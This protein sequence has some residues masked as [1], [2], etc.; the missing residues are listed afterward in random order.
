M[1]RFIVDTQLPPVLASYLCR[2]G[3]D[4]VHTT[5]FTNGHLLADKTIREI[6]VH[7]NRII[8]TKDSDF[9]DFYYK[10]GSPPSL[11][12]LTLG[13]IRNNDLIDWL[14]RQLPTIIKLF[15]EGATMIVA[16]RTHLIS[17]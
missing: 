6:A 4:A 9:P 16:N 17:Y 2:R 1:L 13:N 10:F 11:F 15:E 3:L 12:Y 14:D 5:H 7:E 8:I